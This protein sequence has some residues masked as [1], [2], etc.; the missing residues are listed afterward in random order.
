ME[1]L[2][3]R[4]HYIPSEQ[5]IWLLVFVVPALAPSKQHL[6]KQALIIYSMFS[7]QN[8]SSE[9]FKYLSIA[10][11]L[12]RINHSIDFF[13][14]IS[15]FRTYFFEKFHIPNRLS[16]LNSPPLDRMESRFGMWNFSK[17]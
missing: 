13:Y 10:E 7:S 8:L 15:N 6:P 14:L 9:L 2:C 11:L 16:I 12:E 3:R 1:T 5:M 4:N 17:K